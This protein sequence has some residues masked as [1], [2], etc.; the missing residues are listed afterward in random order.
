MTTARKQRRDFRRLGEFELIR[1][2]TS[3]LTFGKEVVCGPGDDASAVQLAALPGLLL[4]TTDLLIEDVHFRK[5]WGNVYQLGWKALAVNLSDIAA[6]GG[7]PLH[8]HLSLAISPKW[9]DQEILDLQ[10]GFLDLARQ[11]H[12]S[13]LGG[14]LSRSKKHL[15]ISVSVNGV[16]APTAAIFRSGAIPGDII[17][18]SGT[19]GDAAAGLRLLKA[20]EY[21]AASP[22]LL[23]AFLRPH[24]EIE[25]G[26][27]CAANHRAHALIDLSDGLAGD[28][29]HVMEASG[30]GAVLNET[31]LPISDELLS[32]AI[33]RGWNLMD[34]VL[35]GGEDYRL[36]GC[37]PEDQFTILQTEAHSSLKKTLFPIGRITQE[38]GLRFCK[39]SGKIQMIPATAHDHFA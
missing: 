21:G 27:L 31:A 14:D 6:M 17:W 23:E 16:V 13:L 29:G 15:F 30:V 20:G 8:A 26:Q 24:P 37:S 10:R 3:G 38:S 33:E 19:L 36:L 34:M 18:V 35:R 1:E 22:M 2:L 28:L 39:P 7:K 12:V 32:V 9:I 11:Y 5:G 4:Q 25:L